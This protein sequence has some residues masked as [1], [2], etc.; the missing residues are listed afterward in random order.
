MTDSKPSLAELHTPEEI[1]RRLDRGVVHSYLK[2]LV[3]GAIDGTVTTFA[4]V[5]GVAGASLP[6]GVVIVLGCAN[7]LGDGFSMA[8]GNFLGTR[9]ERQLRALARG[10]EYHHIRDFPE[11]EREEIRQ[12]FARK[13]FSGAELESTVAVITADVERWV[14]TMVQEEL[15]HSL[16]GPD[17]WRA[18]VATFFSFCFVGALP[19]LSFVINWLIPGSIENPFF[20]STGLTAAA[21]FAVGALKGKYVAHPWY[22][23]GAETLAVGGVAAG[24][25]YWVGV[26]LKRL[27]VG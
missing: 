16:A 19:L 26:M 11:G 22:L 8:A 20:V 7:L 21:F 12:I 6:S 4:V 15:G 25:A 10:Q 2:D 17:P 1:S 24:L 14:D 18:A 5:A 13:G 9:A 23:A 27:V 3:Y